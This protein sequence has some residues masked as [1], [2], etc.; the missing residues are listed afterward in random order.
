MNKKEEECYLAG[1]NGKRRPPWVANYM[2]GLV[3]AYK[4]G[5]ADKKRGLPL[6]HNNNLNYLDVQKE[7]QKTEK[8]TK[9]DVVTVSFSWR[10]AQTITPDALDQPI[11][12]QTHN[13]KIMTF[14]SC[15]NERTWQWH[16][17]KYNI[18]YWAYQLELC[19]L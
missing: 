4:A 19:A 9:M 14:K 5:K 1:Y 8:I 11:V 17:D 2:T 10:N 12:C 7:K 6:M 18:K 16:V 13:G 3:L 15:G